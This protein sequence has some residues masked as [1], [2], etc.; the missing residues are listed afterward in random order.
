VSKIDP[1]YLKDQ[2][3]STAE[4]ERRWLAQA[5]QARA[6]ANAC[7]GAR[8]AYERMLATLEESA[9]SDKASDDGPSSDQN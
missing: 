9:Q 6:N 5:E 2:I 4:E 8:Q 1:E 7:A 3:A